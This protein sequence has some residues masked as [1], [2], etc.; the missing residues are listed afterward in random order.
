MPGEADRFGV[1]RDCL[2]RGDVPTHD[3]L[4]AVVDDRHRHPAEV[5]ERP[6]VAVEEGL[7]VLAGGEATERI[8][9]VRQHHV[10]RVDLGDAHVGEDVALVAPVDLG[11]SSRDD[12]EAAVQPRQLLGSDA[13][14]LGDPRASLLNVEFDALIVAGEPVLRG[15]P[16][17]DH[18]RLH[19]DLGP[20]HRID[21]RREL[22][23]LPGHHL[24]T[25][26]ATRRSRRTREVLADRLAVQPCLPGDLR[27]AHRTGL[28]QAPKPP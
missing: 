6:P 21:Q 12:L 18:R 24:A 25:G 14:F 15:Q 5:R 28:Q 17:V 16:L 11:L 22:V 10:E 8:A 9:R 13:E 1:Q 26:R 23:D 4:G 2:A 20:Q 19:Q 27:Q 3:G 7:Q